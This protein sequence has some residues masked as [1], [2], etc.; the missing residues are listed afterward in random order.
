LN[1]VFER[2]SPL[3][4]RVQELGMIVLCEVIQEKAGKLR[5]AKSRAVL[6]TKYSEKPKDSS[7]IKGDL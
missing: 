7:G 5:K 6:L 3:E 1:P 2:T 4:D